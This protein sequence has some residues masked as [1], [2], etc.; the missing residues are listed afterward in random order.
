MFASTFNL[1]G[2]T[3]AGVNLPDRTTVGD[4]NTVPERTGLRTEFMVKG[5]VAGLYLKHNSTDAGGIK[6]WHCQL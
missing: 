3:V 6:V 1:Q 4:K 2:A 5:Y